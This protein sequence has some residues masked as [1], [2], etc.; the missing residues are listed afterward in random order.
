MTPPIIVGIGGGSASGKSTFATRLAESLSDLQVTLVGM[1]RYFR[2]E[3]PVAVGPLSGREWPD[4]NQP[5]SF[6]LDRLV[7]DLD[8]MDGDVVI[9]EGLMALV[10]EEVRRRLSIKLF[11]DAQADERIVRRLRRNMAERGLSFDEIADY[12]LDSV[13]YRHAQ[14][15]EP[16]RWHADLVINGASDTGLAVQAVAA[17]IRGFAS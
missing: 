16:S 10:D 7:A 11:V 9:L 14:Y 4:F 1:D 17:L 15:V 5:G 2:Q 13:R 8:A 6:H 3:K 12:Y